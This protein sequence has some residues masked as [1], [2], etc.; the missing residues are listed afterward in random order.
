MLTQTPILVEIAPGELIDKLVILEIKF[1]RI[2]DP[3]KRANVYRELKMLRKCYAR[4]FAHS[5][6]VTGV[7]RL[8]EQLRDLNRELWDI[9]DELRDCERRLDFGERFVELARSVYRTN[10]ERAALKRRISQLYDAPFVEE[11]SYSTY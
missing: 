2:E 4:T 10:D 6:A 11:K 5:A 8:R 1:E 9:E 3:E 7:M